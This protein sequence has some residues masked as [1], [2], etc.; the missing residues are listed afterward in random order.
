METNPK[1]LPKWRVC[2]LPHT[3]VPSVFWGRGASVNFSHL[4]IW[5]ISAATI[6]NAAGCDSKG[7]M[8]WNISNGWLSVPVKKW[9]SSCPVT[10]HWLARTR[11]M[12]LLD[13]KGARKWAPL[14]CLRGNSDLCWALGWQVPAGG[15]VV[16]LILHVARRTEVKYTWT[17]AFKSEQDWN[18][19]LKKLYIYFKSRYNWHTTLY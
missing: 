3:T 9:H 16:S 18:P 7:E 5:A 10:A 12:N 17:Y 4:E 1:T 2:F 19:A 11:P 6:S 8:A 15:S 14:T 13:H